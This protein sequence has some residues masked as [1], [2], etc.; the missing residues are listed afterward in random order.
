MTDT[1]MW[2][3]LVRKVLELD[4]TMLTP[5]QMER[6]ID[7]A[8]ETDEG[9]AFVDETVNA[10][11]NDELHVGV[12]RGYLD[13]DPAGLTPE[14]FSRALEAALDA[15]AESIAVPEAEW[16]EARDWVKANRDLLG[17]LPA[18]SGR[19]ERVGGWCRSVINLLCRL[20]I[21]DGRS[22]PDARELMEDV[23][24]CREQLAVRAEYA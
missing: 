9:R 8:R 6:A 20:S 17:T 24:W 19:P 14:Q 21:D 5:E 10:M 18:V 4:P 15:Y 22:Q 11:S 7:V 12:V 13:I 16:N 1:Q 23:A 3:A 2:E